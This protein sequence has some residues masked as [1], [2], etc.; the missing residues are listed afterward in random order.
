MLD[1]T[2][3]SKLMSDK[4]KITPAFAKAKEALM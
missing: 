1:D 4:L 2:P 3:S